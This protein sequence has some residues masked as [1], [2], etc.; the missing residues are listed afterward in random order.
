MNGPL[1]AFLAAVLF[2][3]STPVSK[4]L[5]GTIGP[6]WMAAILYLGAGFGIGILLVIRKIRGKPV[7]REI[8]A[9]RSEWIWLAGAVLF[10]GVLGPTLLMYGLKRTAGS[11]SALLLNMEGVFTAS[12][13]WIAFR[14]HYNRHIV[15]GMALIVMGGC[16]LSYSSHPEMANIGGPLLVLAACLSWAMDNN[17]TR[18]VS[19]SDPLEITA[20]KSIVAGLT[21]LGLAAMFDSSM[22]PPSASVWLYGGLTGFFGYGLS[23]VCF[24]L[25]LRNLG[26]S[27][28]GAYFSTAPFVGALLSFALLREPITPPFVI[29]GLLMA[30]GVWLH[31]TE[32]HS[33]EHTHEE[34]EHTHS[35]VHDLH[36]QHEHA[37]GAPTGEPHTHLH[38]HERT[39]HAHRHFPDI[40]H[41]HDHS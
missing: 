25:A 41:R 2:G 33:H 40:H 26:T 6:W 20:I 14:E 37:P 12:L 38:R 30:A 13:A 23:L 1:Y 4:L 27:R 34:L 39:T 5:L 22:P 18:K 28:T 10:G 7:F 3:A 32:F 29:A 36:H 24:V 8:F 16:V 35:H 11:T 19:A 17:V 9:K 21:N 31:L 15:A